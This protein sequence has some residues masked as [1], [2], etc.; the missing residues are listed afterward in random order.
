M[1]GNESNMCKDSD[2]PLTTKKET[3]R[4]VKLIAKEYMHAILALPHYLVF[5]M[6][7]AY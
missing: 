7:G 4:V 1:Y 6:E 5:L 2:I 3:R